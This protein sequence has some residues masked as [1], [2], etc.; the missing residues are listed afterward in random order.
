MNTPMAV[1]TRAREFKKTRA[2][3]EAERDSQGAV[4]Q[5]DGHRLGRR[6]RRAVFGLR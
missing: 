2:E 6:Q 3:V 4:A 5:E 1:D